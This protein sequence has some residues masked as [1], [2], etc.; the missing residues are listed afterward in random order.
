MIL[1]FVMKMKI[2]QV[3]DIMSLYLCKEGRETSKIFSSVDEIDKKFLE[4]SKKKY[5][6][7]V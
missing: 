3:F 2:R 1:Q 6:G 4:N 5:D 7:E